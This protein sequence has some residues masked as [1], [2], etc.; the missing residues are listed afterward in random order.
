MKST[1]S[2]GAGIAKV[3]YTPP[4]NYRLDL[5]IFSIGERVKSVNIDNYRGTHRVDFHL[6]IYVTSGQFTHT[7]DFAPIQ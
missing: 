1:N 7:V 2:R 5:E 6:L 4:E 3:E